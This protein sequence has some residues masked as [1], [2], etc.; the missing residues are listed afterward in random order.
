ML[1]F[2]KFFTY[3]LSVW[4]LQ[5]ANE[6]SIFCKSWDKNEKLT[7]EPFGL[8]NGRLLR[9]EED[10]EVM[11]NY[12]LVKRKYINTVEYD[13]NENFR[14]KRNPRKYR[15]KSKKRDNYFDYDDSFDKSFD[16][17][18]YNNRHHS[19]HDKTEYYDHYLVEPNEYEQT[20]PEKVS[21]GSKPRKRT[22]LSNLVNFLKEMDSKFEVA[23][24]RSLKYNAITDDVSVKHKSTFGKLLHYISRHKILLPPFALLVASF[25]VIAL[26]MSETA[27]CSTIIVGLIVTAY[28]LVK[29]IKCNKMSKYYRKCKSGNKNID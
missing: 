28:Y 25:A 5:Y 15:N 6:F 3:A 14:N 20:Y 26:H 12:G 7:S 4:T 8:R 22:T 23:L 18:K 29:V 1:P 27:I 11:R 13:S 2:I 16:S 24:L 21:Y 19:P 17:L 10:I 9:G